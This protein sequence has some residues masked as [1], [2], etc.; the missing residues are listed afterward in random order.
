MNTPI[1]ASHT[2]QAGTC[3]AATLISTALQAGNAAGAA[4]LLSAGSQA[5]ITPSSDLLHQFSSDARMAAVLAQRSQA[6]PA[7]ALSEG[8][9][10]DEYVSSLGRQAAAEAAHANVGTI[11]AA[12][13]VVAEFTA[14]VKVRSKA[15]GGVTAHDC[16]PEDVAVFFEASWLQQHGSTLLQDGGVY[17]APSYL[18]S[19]V[20]HLSGLFKRLGR[21]GAYNY[22]F[23]VC[24]E[25]S[26]MQCISA[27]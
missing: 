6:A 1:S 18:D 3:A 27:W 16:T 19:A 14:W 22:T 15:R 5:G 13:S 24:T 8:E 11:A 17:A 12:S 25:M 2:W 21:E 26:L 20:S 10:L 7:D 9:V 4:A 23:Q